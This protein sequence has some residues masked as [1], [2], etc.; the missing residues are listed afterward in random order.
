MQIYKPSMFNYF[1]Q[2]DS[3]MFLYNT[4]VGIKSI[5]NV[6]P[7]KVNEVTKYLTDSQMEF[8][9]EETMV[10][11]RDKGFLVPYAL[12]EKTERN[13]FYARHLNDGVLRLVIHT[14]KACNFRCNYCALEFCEESL[15]YETQNRII[16]FVQKKLHSVNRVE[17][18]WFGGEP[19]LNIKAIE[20]ISHK[21][22]DLCRRARKV[23]HATITT[24]GFLLTEENIEK[25]VALNVSGYTVTM[26]G[27]EEHHDAQRVL[28]DGRPTFQ[29]ILSNL[30]YIKENIKNTNIRVFIRINV[31][32]KMVIS[33]NEVY[34]FYNERFRDDKRFSLFIRTVVDGGGERIK[35]MKNEILSQ[36]ETDDMVVSMSKYSRKDGIKYESNF[37]YLNPGGFC[38]MAMYFQKYT[39]DVKGNAY[40]CDVI[41]E[42]TCIGLLDEHGNIVKSGA[43]EAEWVAGAWRNEEKCDEC[44]MSPLCF[45]GVCPMQRLINNES[46]CRMVADKKEIKSLILLYAASNPIPCL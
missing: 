2:E 38:C 14:T 33:L 20:Y 42:E 11:L 10:F 8:R 44:F 27:L 30:L 6:H 46:A 29:T 43:S 25:L 15:S 13:F 18:N 3:Q 1:F 34:A 31:T 12:D 17:I 22:I 4:F 24:N 39:F 37:S 23:Y 41:D 26:D 21:I 45:K 32:K 36:K 35:K 7:S 16:R 28:C 5:C 19:L 9:N 40:K